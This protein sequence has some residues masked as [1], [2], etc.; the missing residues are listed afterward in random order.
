M[1]LRVFHDDSPVSEKILRM[2]RYFVLACLLIGLIL[3][4]SGVFSKITEEYFPSDHPNGKYSLIYTNNLIWQIIKEEDTE[5]F[6]HVKRYISEDPDDGEV[7]ILSRKQGVVLNLNLFL[8]LGAFASTISGME[9]VF[10]W[11]F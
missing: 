2:Y 6:L 8:Q 10:R 7:L 11:R 5:L 9:Q 4:F 3:L 1:L